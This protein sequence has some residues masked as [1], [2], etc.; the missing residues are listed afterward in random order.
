MRARR[1]SI[2]ALV[3]IF[4]TAA[5][6]AQLQ[7][8]AQAQATL[9]ATV[10]ARGIPTIAPLLASVTPAVVN[11]T[12]VSETTAPDNGVFQDPFFS[13]F[14]SPLRPQHRQR[15]VAAGSGVIVDAEKGYVLTNN[16]VVKNGKKVTVTLKD[17]RSFDARIIGTD[18]ATDIAVLQIPAEHL[19]ALAMGN[20]ENL[21][22]GDFVVAVG[23]PFGL[24]Q[25][26]TSG[27]VSALGR[28]GI[29]PQGFEDFIQ[30]DASINPGNSGGALVTFDGR[31]V[32]INTA[33][34]APSGGNVGIGFAI[35]VN[36][37]RS[38][39]E[40]LIDFG[41][42]H[43]GLLGVVTQ[44]LTPEI[45]K[46]LGLDQADGALVVQVEPG[47]PAEAA[48]LEPG[49]VIVSVNGASISN[50]RDLRGHLGVMRADTDFSLEI[51]RS[52][53]R[54]KLTARL[55]EKQTRRETAQSRLLSGAL[56]APLERGMPGFGQVRGVAV[57][58]V[59]A[60]SPAARFGLRPADVIMAVNKTRVESVEALD[61]ELSGAGNT[62]A[63]LIWR[64]G[65]TIY[66]LIRP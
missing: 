60:G 27:I 22:V 10:D 48:G 29:N 2:P 54:H 66:L 7:A 5:L 65:A 15:Q 44:D 21:K 55:S 59:A 38:V 18:P 46:A 31:L 56:L 12:V 62:I 14:F 28:T 52:D 58:D 11:I 13:P 50:A 57:V 6:P 30:T 33:I 53:G 51:V 24:G 42:V 36:M 45:G 39:M 8:Q 32:G 63:M 61:A 9:P 3:L 40:Q 64:H 35:P 17:K 43:R 16:H 26:V 19:T 4:L 37:A 20:S 34:I 23:N 25:T 1:L 49:D 41:K 47:S